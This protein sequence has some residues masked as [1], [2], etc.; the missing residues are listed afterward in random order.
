MGQTSRLITSTMWDSSACGS[1][2]T[3]PGWSIKEEIFYLDFR[4]HWTAGKGSGHLGHPA[5][6]YPVLASL[7]HAVSNAR[8]VNGLEVN[9]L[10]WNQCPRILRKEIRLLLILRY[11]MHIREGQRTHLRGLCLA[12]SVTECLWVRPLD[13]SL[14]IWLAPINWI[15]LS[16]WPHAVSRSMTLPG[17][18]TDWLEFGSSTIFDISFL[19]RVFVLLS[20]ITH[21]LF[22]CE[23]S[24]SH[25]CPLCSQD[26]PYRHK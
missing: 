14:V 19:L 3:W 25:L 13:F 4:S 12:T 17:R 6:L 21:W 18:A 1:S 15:P 5:Q 9:G 2:Y 24:D 8:Q 16:P 10:A 11:S 7:S 22:F 23:G 20:I 26:K